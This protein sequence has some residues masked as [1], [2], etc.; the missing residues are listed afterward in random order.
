M[1]DC[2]CRRCGNTAQEHDK[3]CTKC[4]QRMED[5][6]NIEDGD[7]TSKFEE[8]K[9]TVKHQRKNFFGSSKSVRNITKKVNKIGGGDNNEV[10]INVGIVYLGTNGHLSKK[11]GSR[12]PVTVKEL[13]TEREV[14]KVAV[15]KISENDQYFCGGLEAYLL[16]YPDFRVVQHIPGTDTPFSIGEYKRY[17]GKPYSKLNLNVCL[18][19][20]LLMAK[21]KDETDDEEEPAIE[22]DNVASSS[23]D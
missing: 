5:G 18:Q 15:K 2:F 11:R 12:M 17:L 7:I 23:M 3:Y 13:F 19:T 20:H 21:P 14:L 8:Y 10:K 9:E 6:G 22:E 16:I 1:A 4:G